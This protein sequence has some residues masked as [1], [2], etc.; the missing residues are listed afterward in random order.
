MRKLFLEA[1]ER[2]AEIPMTVD[3]DKLFSAVFF[4]F[5]RPPALH[6]KRDCWFIEDV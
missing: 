4:F 2:W 5:N 1:G 3:K 6:E